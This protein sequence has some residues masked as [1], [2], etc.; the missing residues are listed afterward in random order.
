MY[1]VSPTGS[2]YYYT[3]VP[4]GD[5]GYQLPTGTIT[6]AQIIT[7][8]ELWVTQQVPYSQTSWWTNANGTYRQ[9]C[10]GYVSMAWDLDQYTDFW[11]GNLNLVSRTIPAATMLP[12]DILLSDKHTILF[13]GWADTQHTEF[14]YFEEAHPGTDARYVVDAPL[15]AFLDN[16]FAPFRYD[17]VVNSSA[18]PTLPTGQSYSLLASEGSEVDPPGV[19]TLQ[20]A[21]LAASGSLSASASAS[22]SSSAK[23]AVQA[24]TAADL[25]A[26]EISRRDEG[27][28]LAVGGFFLLGAGLVM[29]RPIRSLPRRRGKH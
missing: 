3:S 18:L 19:S 8:A 21:G 27:V 13:A 12:G 2:S 9:D 24:L 10:S 14:D 29:R 22:A 1:T 20:P 16:G 6:R 11:T 5:A 4:P 7:R 15:S 25:A 28:A 23:P 26:A 17:G